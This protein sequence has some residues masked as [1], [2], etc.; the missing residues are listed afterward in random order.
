MPLPP[1]PPADIVRSPNVEAAFNLLNNRYD[2]AYHLLNSGSYEL[3]RVKFHKGVVMDHAVH[4]IPALEAAM[5]DEH[6]PAEWIQAISEAYGALIAELL[7]AEKTVKGSESI[8]VDYLQPVSVVRTGRPGRP[9]K[10]IDPIFLKQAM[11]KGRRI[12]VTRLA[13]LTGVHRHTLRYYLK[14]HGIDYKFS[15]L[16]DEQLDT[17]TR[18]FKASKVNSG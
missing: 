5:Y 10:T 2:A 12:S 14:K 18:L 11:G 13:K 4:T 7:H 8:G 17:I 9:R 6:L 3:H 15:T 1:P 16:T